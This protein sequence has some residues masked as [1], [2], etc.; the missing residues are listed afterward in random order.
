MD[1]HRTKIVITILFALFFNSS[2]CQQFNWAKRIGNVGMEDSYALALDNDGGLY[3][4]GC[5]SGTVDFNPGS[6]VNNLTVSYG[7][8]TD[9]HISKLDSAGNYQW[10]INFGGRGSD[11]IRTIQVDAAKNVYVAG[12]FDDTA[13]FDPGPNVFTLIPTGNES[14]FIAKY[15]STGALIWAK[16]ITGFFH[17]YASALDIDDAGSIYVTGNFVDTVDFDPGPNVY[18]LV[19]NSM[20]DAYILKLNNN[21]DFCWAKD[22]GQQ[23]FDIGYDIKT[24][25]FGH[26]YTLGT[27]RLTVDFDP[28]VDTFNLTAT[29]YDDVFL[30]KLDTAGSFVW[31]KSFGGLSFDYGRG[32]SIDASGNA[33][34]TGSFS[35]TVDFNPGPGVFNITQISIA[36]D[37]IFVSKLDS[38]GNF[39]WAKQ[40]GGAGAG[41]GASVATDIVGNVYTTGHF[42]GVTDFNPGSGVLNFT[43]VGLSGA[44]IYVVKLSPSG[45]FN[46][47]KQVAGPTYDYAYAIKPDA[48]GNVYYT[49]FFEGTVDFD[50]GSTTFNLISA[51]SHDIF[52]SKLG[53]TI[54]NNTELHHNEQWVAY[55]N[56][57]SGKF[58]LRSS[59]HRND[60]LVT[61]RNIQG[62]EI[63]SKYFSNAEHLDLEINDADGVYFIEI[64][65]ED[66][67]P[68][69]FKIL[70]VA[71]F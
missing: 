60:A 50:I 62:Q 6:G 2:F 34:M 37:D 68:V 7:I 20:Y 27:Y 15:D 36:G 48:L 64:K 29:G 58:N 12:T 38:A 17:V 5:F 33:I 21:G 65:S 24:D 44:D 25:H 61:I 46:W 30:L 69:Q 40:F 14:V 26:V 67:L 70:K 42:D 41:Y 4:G 19:T 66:Q 47:A 71:G 59:D 54:T 31:A 56:P 16:G 45:N 35:S 3:T 28:G 39:L 51:G 53:G 1:Q 49:G 10:A 23:T 52:I 8:N 22:I 32:L 55:P 9:A 18:Q 43:Q 57:T 63:S 11:E 13:D